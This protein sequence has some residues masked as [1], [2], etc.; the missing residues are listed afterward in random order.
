MCTLMAVI[1]YL[2]QLEPLTP[3]L[4]DML[5]AAGSTDQLEVAQWLRQQGAE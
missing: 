4:T 2:H 1:E 3:V 5:N